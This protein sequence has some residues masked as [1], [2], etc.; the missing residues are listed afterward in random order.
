MM[1]SCPLASVIHLGVSEAVER[2]LRQER[3]A[4]RSTV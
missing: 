3:T 4:V 2:A 1:F